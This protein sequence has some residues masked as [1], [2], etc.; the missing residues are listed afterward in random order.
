MIVKN[1]AVSGRSTKSFIDEGRWDKVKSQ[2]KPGDYVLVQFGSNDQ[3]NQDPKRYTDPETTFKDN[4][5]K[6]VSETREEGGIPLLA[7]S[8]V[9]RRWNKE[10]E[11]MDTHGRYV[12]AVREI[13]KEMNVPIIDMQI[14]TRQLVEQYGEEES[15]KLYLW[16]ESGVAE[17][18]PEGNKDDTHINQ[19]GATEFSR[20]FAKELQLTKHPLADY[21]HDNIDTIK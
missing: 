5:R 6:F 21:L 17:R 13:A 18:F 16:V 4:F 11:L 3:K 1:Y 9:R 2:I 15:K 10:G 7:T 19:H 8:I 12:E 14:S 20:L